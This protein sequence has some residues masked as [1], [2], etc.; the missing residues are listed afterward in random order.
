[1]KKAS[2]YGLS[3]YRGFTGRWGQDR[4]DNNRFSKAFDLVP[5]HRLLKKIATTRVDLRVV[6]LVKE[7]LLGRFRR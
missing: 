6:V 4:R 7:F 3:G 1:M 5:H 2:S